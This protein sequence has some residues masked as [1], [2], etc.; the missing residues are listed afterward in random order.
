MNSLPHPSSDSPRRH[1]PASEERGRELLEMPPKLFQLKDLHAMSPAAM[2]SR[3][4]SSA[5]EQYQFR[6]SPQQPT[7]N[8]EIATNPSEKN[9]QSPAAGDETPAGRGWAELILSHRKALALLLVVIAAAFWTSQRRSDSTI[10]SLAIEPTAAELGIETVM[11]TGP[12]VDLG[13]EMSSEG[14]APTQGVV[15][16]P[17]APVE[18]PIAARDPNALGLVANQPLADSLGVI[19]DTVNASTVM[20]SAGTLPAQYPTSQ[21]AIDS[22]TPIPATANP[23]GFQVRTVSSQT[24]HSPQISAPSMEDLEQ[25]AQEAVQGS[26]VDHRSLKDV[27]PSSTPFGPDDWLDYLPEIKTANP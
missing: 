4:I 1:R 12:I 17:T 3:A 26:G 11:G 27:Q 20:T 8:P 23:P 5:E 9:Q 10:D 19:P 6:S 13:I 15:Q 18:D 2:P 7:V 14:I 16:A 21:T 24:P 25:A 22:I